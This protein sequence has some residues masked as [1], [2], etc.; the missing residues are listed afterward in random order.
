M[1]HPDS[2]SQVGN[3][4]L[5]LRSAVFFVAMLIST[6]VI[7]PIM[8]LA[9]PLRFRVCYGIAQVWVVLNLWLLK[10]I[11]GIDHE[12]RGREN[13]P[14]QPSIILCKHQSAWETIALQR[15]FP[16]QV[17]IIKRELVWLPFFG[18][19]L[20]TCDPIAIDRKAGKTALRQVVDQV[21]ER[22]ESGRWVV[23]FPEGTR[24]K[25]GE[26]GRYGGGGAVLAKKSGFQV[27]PVAHNA[28]KFWGRNSFLKHPGTVQLLIG[29]PISPVNR[30][31]SEITEA[32]KS[33]IEAQM[34]E[35]D[36]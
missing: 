15:I 16:A 20:A 6:I 1:M 34:K 5:Y 11:C 4:V 13:I 23:I 31:S 10:V 2:S 8:W 17:F 30:K 7:A 12:V 26:V 25:T 9:F 29:K 21:R 28:G 36:A 27:I 24:V 3:A 14:D 18:W 19:A 22:L 32:A 35:I 33:W